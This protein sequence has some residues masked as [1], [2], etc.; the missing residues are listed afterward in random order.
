M[1][2]DLISI[3]TRM[4]PYHFT[5][6][7]SP[8]NLCGGETRR[9]VG[10]RD[11]YG[12]KLHTALCTNCGLV[13][14]DPMPTEEEV[15]HYYTRFYRKHYHNVVTPRRKDIAA[16]FRG[17]KWRY[18][19][20]E[21]VIKAGA[22]VVDV[23]AG[24]GEFTAY[25]CQR[26]VDAMGIEP[27]Q[28]YAEYAQ[29][30]YKVP[31]INATWA[32]ADIKPGTIGVVSANHVVEHFHSPFHALSRFR[33]WLAPGGYLYLAVPNAANARRTPYSRFHFA[34][35]YYFTPVTLR[36]MAHKVG[37]EETDLCPKDDTIVVLQK[38][39]KPKP[40]WFFAPNHGQ[41][42]DRFFHTYT[43]RRYFLTLRPYIRWFTRM[44]RLIKIRLI[45]AF[46]PR[47]K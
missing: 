41:E 32:N 12:H 44:G 40:G 39:D 38:I 34:H 3:F 14:L 10:R 17:A 25:L 15:D 7:S 36:M 24:G 30:T 22:K 4:A 11:R 27:N 5:G 29:Q 16:A 23:G 1:L 31:I 8:C 35:L 21:P 26:G 43:N 33:E 47:L 20:I 13:F 42:M 45:G 2:N 18:E 28:G 6:E 46:M 37:F 19:L 9:T